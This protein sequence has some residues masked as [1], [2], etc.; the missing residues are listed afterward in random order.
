MTRV[1]AKQV[2]KRCCVSL[3]ERSTFHARREEFPVKT[4]LYSPPSPRDREHPCRLVLSAVSGC[5]ATPPAAEE[6]SSGAVAASVFQFPAIFMITI[7]A[8]S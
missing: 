1:S 5:R 7:W 3:A 8:E 2:V 4:P 6:R